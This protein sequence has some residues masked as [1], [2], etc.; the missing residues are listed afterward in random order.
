MLYFQSE[1]PIILLC[2]VNWSQATSLFFCSLF[3]SVNRCQAM[4]IKLRW[5]CLLLGRSAGDWED[6]L[7][8]MKCFPLF[9]VSI[10]WYFSFPSH[11]ME[12]CCPGAQH[13]N[14]DLIWQ[15]QDLSM[16]I[17]GRET[18]LSEDYCLLTW[19][20]LIDHKAIICV[21]GKSP[22]LMFPLSV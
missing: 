14:V 17:T 22:F 7:C 20:A 2:N 5:L 1:V 15:N 6:L 4:C 21:M 8:A 19:A 16:N 12:S 13:L 18:S 3:C 11:P 9:C 10:C